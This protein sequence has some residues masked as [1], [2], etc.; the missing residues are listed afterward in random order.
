MLEVLG[1]LT[2]AA[3]LVA[4]LS[5]QTAPLVA[6]SYP[7][8]EVLTSLEMYWFAKLRPPALTER[9]VVYCSGPLFNLSEVLYAVG[10]KGLLPPS[11]SLEVLNGL[12]QEQLQGVAGV[13]E[14]LGLNPYGICGELAEQGLDAYVPARDG[15]TLALILT[16]IDQ[17]ATLPESERT[18]LKGYMSKAIYAIDAFCLGG[19][20]NCGLFNANGLQLDDGS[21]TEVGMMGMR[22]MPIVIYR[23]QA[24]S[25]LGPGV[26]NPMPIGNASSTLSPTGYP[27][28]QT[29]VDALKTKLANIVSSQPAWVG[30]ARY[31]HE[32]PPPPLYIYW[33]SVGEAVFM[34]KFRSKQIV[35]N[36]HGQLDMQ[37]SYTPFFFERFQSN[38]SVRNIVEVAQKVAR[39]IREVE[40]RFEGLVQLYPEAMSLPSGT[41]SYGL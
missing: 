41:A 16:A 8:F 1:L 24:T 40:S 20:C 3:L 33:Q 18:D 7:K 36:D 29:A 2:I 23:D 39:V 22:G 14:K 28:V 21:A 15:F 25:Q 19:I 30:S 34:T 27:T 37:S 6:A 5:R 32:V 38:P 10:W 31:S 26:Q 9:A 13:A 12:S 17:D 4:L 11:N 35:V